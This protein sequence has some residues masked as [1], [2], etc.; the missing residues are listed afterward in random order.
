VAV[1]QIVVGAAQLKLSNIS[2][3]PTGPGSTSITINF[4]A[5]GNPPLLTFTLL[6]SPTLNGEFTTIPGAVITGSGGSYQATFSTTSATE[7]YIIEETQ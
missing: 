2:A 4:T 5:P 3:V 7:F 6:G 1:A